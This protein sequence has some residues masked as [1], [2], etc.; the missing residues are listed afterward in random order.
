M[1]WLKDDLDEE[2]DF[3]VNDELSGDE[4]DAEEL[5][6]VSVNWQNLKK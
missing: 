5:S 4:E 6:A 2:D 3:I 1:F